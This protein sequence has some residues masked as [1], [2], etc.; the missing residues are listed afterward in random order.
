MSYFALLSNVQ[1]L[2]FHRKLNVP[3]SY[4]MLKVDTPTYNA[5]YEQQ[6]IILLEVN[7]EKPSYISTLKSL[8]FN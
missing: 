2:E 8:C 7:K 1:L 3:L 6:E 5:Q 4:N